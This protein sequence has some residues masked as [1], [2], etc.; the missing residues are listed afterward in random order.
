MFKIYKK[1]DG[2]IGEIPKYTKNCWIN[3]TD[4]TP[5]E[6]AKLQK[7]F[8]VPEEF[9]EDI[10]DIDERS[11]TEINGRWLLIVIRIPV[12]LP[13]SD[14]S[15]HTIPLGVLISNNMIITL[16]DQE[17]EI[18]ND[19]A[20]SKI[21]GID[22]EN[23]HNFVLYLFQLSASYYLRF[24]KIITRRT[25][26]IE[27]DI[28][29]SIENSQLVNLL[30]IQKCL[31]Y[32]VTS[33][34]SNEFLLNKLQKAKFIDNSM[35][36]EELL[37]DVQIDN[38]QAIETAT[39]HS[40]ILTGMMD[41]FASVISNNLNVVMKRLTVITLCVM[42][43]SVFSGLFGMNVPNFAEDSRYAFWGV[44]AASLVLTAILVFIFRKLRWF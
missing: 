6:I 15:F 23:M 26:Q 24:M 3:V 30:K 31:V 19:I 33:L 36:D 5:E 1:V 42:I 32:F 37:E 28:R 18:I 9:I 25:N 44:V 16:C 22:I 41:A 8:H 11:R 7:D 35:L 14:I 4:P 17:N 27:K 10:L 12:Y 39:I 13:K 2:K 29:K 43:P 20:E 40:D 38:K 21:K 34:R